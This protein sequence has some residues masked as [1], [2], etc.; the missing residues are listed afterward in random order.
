MGESEGNIIKIRD[1]GDTITVVLPYNPDHISRIKTIKGSRWH[2]AERHWTVPRSE[3][4]T[5][6][7]LFAHEKK[8]VSPTLLLGDLRKEMAARGYSP[9]TITIYMFYN[10]KIIEHTGKTPADITT[11]DIRDYLARLTEEHRASAST[12]NTAISA[13]KFHQNQVLGKNLQI[14]RPRKDQSLPP[15]LN[16]TEIKILLESTENP[17]HKALLTLAY[18]AGLR[19]SEIVSL[20]PE[21]IDTRRMLIHIKKAKRRK[22]RY[23]PLSPTALRTLRE[24]LRHSGHHTYLFP[25]QRP[26][27]HISTRTAEKIFTQALKRAGIRKQASIH[28]LR[29]SFATHLLENGTDIRYIQEILGHKSTKTT[30]IYTHITTQ[31][32]SQI[33][34]PLDAMMGQDLRPRKEEGNAHRRHKRN[35]G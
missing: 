19:V 10:T 28:T 23:V 7:S 13:I 31:K 6:L 20:R 18:S 32:L 11:R 1:T 25:G 12:L 30:Q 27:T 3:T 9:R 33:P 29:H 4:E 35:G 15:V 34:N 22:D 8:T 21:D 2:P 24:Y 17:K 26:G 16:R 14:K 5:L